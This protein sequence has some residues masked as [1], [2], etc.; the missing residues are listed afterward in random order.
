ML[1]LFNLK[2][3]GKTAFFSVL[4]ILAS[5][6][7]STS[8]HAGSLT[9]YQRD[10]LNPSIASCSI[11]PGAA[12][13][14]G[15][16]PLTAEEEIS[17]EDLTCGFLFVTYDG[18]IIDEREYSVSID[19]SQS[20]NVVE[21]YHC[22][23]GGPS[24]YNVAI[25]AVNASTG[26]QISERVIELVDPE[27]AKG[28]C[29]GATPC[30]TDVDE[31]ITKI[32][33]Q[34]TAEGK[35]FLSWKIG[36]NIVSRREL[37]PSA[38]ESR[39]A[40]GLS[41]A[42]YGTPGR[43]EPCNRKLFTAV[44]APLVEDVFPACGHVPFSPGRVLD[45]IITIW[46][47]EEI[48]WA[49][50]GGGLPCPGCETG[51]CPGFDITLRNMDGLSAFLV[52]RGE[53]AIIAKSRQ[54]KGHALQLSFEPEFVDPKKRFVRPGADL[55]IVPHILQKEPRPKVGRTERVINLELNVRSH[56][57]KE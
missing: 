10:V 30:Q 15:E 22:A 31:D 18:F 37:S 7:T 23:G 2:V 42:R 28:G 17:R 45:D 3:V 53:S 43:R 19:E 25:A 56:I 34:P 11:C 40:S 57:P 20:V 5:S 48:C 51:L 13:I 46:P 54:L 16:L 29:Y 47:L 55:V 50:S 49:V 14:V 35:V 4:L 12:D 32:V 52:S 36:R 8:A 38:G 6:V 9:V 1:R 21:W 41:V 24:R 44:G 26:S 33:A 39:V 27:S